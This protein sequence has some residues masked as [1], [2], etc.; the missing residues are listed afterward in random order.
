MNQTMV[1]KKALHSILIYLY[2][3]DSNL[4]LT[5]GDKNITIKCAYVRECVHEIKYFSITPDTFLRVISSF[6]FKLIRYN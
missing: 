6:D 3:I 1:R 4:R 2:K 5:A